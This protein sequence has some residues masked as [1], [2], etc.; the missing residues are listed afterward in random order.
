MAADASLDS[1]IKIAGAMVGAG[2]ALGRG[3]VGAS[4]GDGLAGSQTIAGIAR[5]PEG[6]GTSDDD[7]VPH[8][9]SVRGR[10]LHQPGLR[11]PLRLL[12][13][14]VATVVARSARPEGG[15][16]RPGPAVG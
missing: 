12:P 14:Q 4:I 13:G 6:P 1:A 15:H 11:R 9:G 16:P 3:A 10:L 2:L 5:Q 7:H 8:R